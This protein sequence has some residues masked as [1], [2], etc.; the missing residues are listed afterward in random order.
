MCLSFFE[1]K[2]HLL[3][4]L[5]NVR[6]S[7]NTTAVKLVLAASSK[8]LKVERLVVV[9]QVSSRELHSQRHLAVGWHDPPEMIQPADDHTGFSSENASFVAWWGGGGPVLLGFCRAVRRAPQA[10]PPCPRPVP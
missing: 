1:N 7:T 5:A 6:I 9:P 8:D 2:R 3:W 10:E 4:V